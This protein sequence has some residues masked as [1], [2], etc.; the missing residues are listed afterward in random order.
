ML[1]ICVSELGEIGSDKACLLFGAKSLSELMLEYCQLDNCEQNSVKFESIWKCFHSWKCIW[2]YGMHNGG[3]LVQGEM[4][5]TNRDVNVV[6]TAGQPE[7]ISHKEIMYCCILPTQLST[8]WVDA[9]PS[10]MHFK[11]KSETFQ[12]LETFPNTR[13]QNM[14]NSDQ[15]I[16]QMQK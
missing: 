16:N 4:S 9:G 5:V 13:L 8:R 12:F 7:C 10:L 1:H 14:F 2:K 3:Y 11:N 6:S 15:I